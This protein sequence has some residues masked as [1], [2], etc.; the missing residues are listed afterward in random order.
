MARRIIL[1]LIQAYI[2]VLFVYIVLSWF[3]GSTGSGGV[4][5]LRYALG[6]ITEPVLSPI[7]RL[8]PATRMGG[9]GIDWSPIIVFFVLEFVVVRIVAAL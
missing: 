6:R 3:P 5:R 2:A 1:D 7:R 8:L 9:V 4:A